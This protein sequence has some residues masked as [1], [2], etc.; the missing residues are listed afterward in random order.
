M[1][2]PGLDLSDYEAE[3]AQKIT[4]R[5]WTR[6]E[7]LRMYKFRVTGPPPIGLSG[8]PATSLQEGKSY[9]VPI[10]AA[11]TGPTDVPHDW[12]RGMAAQTT[13]WITG[14]LYAAMNQAI[15]RL[16][17]SLWFEEQV[18]PPSPNDPQ[19]PLTYKCRWQTGDGLRELIQHRLETRLNCEI[20]LGDPKDWDDTPDARWNPRDLMITNKGLVIPY[21][22][23]CPKVD[24]LLN[25]IVAGAAGNPVF[26]NTIPSHGE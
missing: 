9:L 18:N 15:P 5:V 12:M 2:P 3:E 23:E 16:I 22:H 13:W 19:F 6:Y 11:P 26:T 24:K 8:V 10:T 14:S 20:E 1:P 21:P 17:A 7:I 25:D 4:D